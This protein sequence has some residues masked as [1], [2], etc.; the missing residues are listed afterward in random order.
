MRQNTDFIVDVRLLAFI[1]VSLCVCSSA[2]GENSSRE[3]EKPESRQAVLTAQR[4]AKQLQL[5]RYETSKGER[6]LLGYEKR[7]IWTKLTE[8][9]YRGA[10]LRLGGMP[11]GSGFVFG[12]GYVVG[13]E[14]EDFV[15]TVDALYS[16]K[17]YTQL[18]SRLKYQTPAP[19]QRMRFFVGADYHRYKSVSFFGLGGDSREDDDTSFQDEA[20]SLGFGAGFE[21]H[22]MVEVEA[23]ARILNTNIGSGADA[24]SFEEI[25]D[26][27]LLPGPEGSDYFVYGGN[28][29]FKWLDSG[30]PEAGIVVISGAERFSDRDDDNFNFTRVIG[31]L[32]VHVPLGYRSRRL[33]FRART[34][35]SLA[36]SGQVIPFHAMETIGGAR[37]L[38][39]FSEF[40]FR[41]T[42]NLIMNLEYRWEVWTYADMALF[43]DWGKVFNR[44]GDLDLSDLE[45]SNGIGFRFHLPG[46]GTSLRL[47]LARSPEGIVFHIGGGPKF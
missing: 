32:Q 3:E 22:R 8:K 31:E 42:R 23:A 18:S 16:T 6:L 29:R 24:P 10:R 34:S 40:R 38:R 17:N 9:G 13:F 45:A 7:P 25:F 44:F 12:G 35:H 39:G 21:P 46:T 4:Q 30:Y 19:D 26:V 15:F 37:S 27:D 5:E 41:D 28:V 11:S 33:A 43:T 14:R 20:R 47:D 2:R 1:F 36:D